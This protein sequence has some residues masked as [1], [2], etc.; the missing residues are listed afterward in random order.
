MQKKLQNK[1]YCTRAALTIDQVSEII[2]FAHF[3]IDYVPQNV[4]SDSLGLVLRFK[5]QSCYSRSDELFFF[6]RKYCSDGT[7][8]SRFFEIFKL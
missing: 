5:S 2:P 7:F 8:I 4:L 1:K 6:I 3:T